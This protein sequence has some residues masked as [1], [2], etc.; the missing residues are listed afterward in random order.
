M[1]KDYKYKPNIW[2]QQDD[3]EFLKLCLLPYL[4]YRALWVC[5]VALF[6]PDNSTMPTAT[7]LKVAAVSIMTNLLFII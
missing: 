7:D 1:L 5:G 3:E 2:Y 6:N 4:R